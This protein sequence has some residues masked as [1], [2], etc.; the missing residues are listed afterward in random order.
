LKLGHSVHGQRQSRRRGASESNGGA[1]QPGSEKPML[2]SNRS[3]WR[4][5]IQRAMAASDAARLPSKCRERTPKRPG[6]IEAQPAH[7][8]QPSVTTTPRRLTVF[9][10]D[11]GCLPRR[12]PPAR[13]GPRAARRRPPPG[14]RRHRVPR[15]MEPDTS[16]YI[17]DEPN[18]AGCSV[19][20]KH[21]AMFLVRF[22]FVT[23][24]LSTWPP[25]AI[26]RY[27]LNLE[28]GAPLTPGWAT[29]LCPICPTTPP[30]SGV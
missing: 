26:S 27:R 22:I 15:S 18:V 5:I 19:G 10:R 1:P 30:S 2:S 23:Q 12:R 13:L 9:G 16:S 25:L 17:R 4:V 3:R 21:R 20:G 28:P 8:S 11:R 24:H 29:P 7:D 6:S 14:R